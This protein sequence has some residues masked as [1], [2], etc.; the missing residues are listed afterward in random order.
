MV[1]KYY[2]KD[3]GWTDNGDGTFSK[4]GVTLNV[5]AHGVGGGEASQYYD[6][7]FDSGKDLDL[8]CAEADW[9]LNYLSLIHI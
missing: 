3:K 8:Y 1:K 2:C 9:A 6:Q 5:V 4:D 7:Y